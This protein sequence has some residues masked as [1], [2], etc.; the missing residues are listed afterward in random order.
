MI[1]V[2]TPFRVSFFGGG[3]D[4][5]EWFNLNGGSVISTSINKYVYLFINEN[6]NL[7]NNFQLEYSI[8]ENTNKVSEIKHPCF[9]AFI[10]Y[11]KIKKAD[12]IFKS[13]LPAFSGLASSSA[14]AVSLNNFYLNHFLD[15][16]PSKKE[17][18]LNSI[19]FE[20][21]ILKENVG[22]QDQIAVTYGGMNLINFKKNNFKIQKVNLNEKNILKIQKNFFILDTG[23]KRFSN[24]IQKKLVRK[25]EF[26]KLSNNFI[27]EMST[28]PIISKKLFEKG[29]IK[30]IGYLLK[31]YW[32]L[33]IKSNPYSYNNDI[34]EIYKISLKY[35]AYS[36]KLL[37]AGSGGFFLFYVEDKN[38]EKFLKINKLFNIY[39]LELEFKGSQFYHL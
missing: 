18:A 7:N 30:E 1:L 16:K 25:F 19:N 35:G 10:K 33:K 23:I 14:L 21:N 3:S 26:S 29:D 8:K 31:N 9:R 36:G 39:P 37:G 22:Y 17:I 15:K 6:N 13:D 5:P 11:Y 4:F 2:K 32:D 12:Y 24:T 34:D 38:L 27:K 28:Y 20:R